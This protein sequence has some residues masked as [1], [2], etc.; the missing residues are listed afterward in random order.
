M[1][2]TQ[3]VESRPRRFATSLAWTSLCLA[4]TIA[5]ASC[6]KDP[7]DSTSPAEVKEPGAQAKASATQLPGAR[8]YTITPDSTIGFVGSKVTGSHNGG[9]KKFSGEFALADGKLTGSG[10][11]LVIDMDS[12]WA[13][14]EKLTGHLKSPDFFD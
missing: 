1:N 2:A 13:D 4:A 6:A 11:K 7:A 8:V 5:L 14:N 9:F 12:T 3:T 10:H